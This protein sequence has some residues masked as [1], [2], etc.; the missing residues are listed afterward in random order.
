[1]IAK[2]LFRALIICKRKQSL[3]FVNI[4]WSSIKK[5]ELMILWKF[6]KN[7]SLENL[8]LSFFKISYF[9]N[10]GLSWQWQWENHPENIRSWC[11]HSLLLRKIQRWKLLQIIWAN[12]WK[13]CWY[14]KNV[15][16]NWINLNRQHCEKHPIFQKK[17]CLKPVVAESPMD[18]CLIDLVVMEKNPSKDKSNKIC[19]Y[20]RNILNVFSRFVFLMPLRTKETTEIASHLHTSF[21]HA[22]LPNVIQCDGGNEFKVNLCFL[23]VFVWRYDNY[24]FLWEVLPMFI[25]KICA[26]IC[27]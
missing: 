11:N 21:L 10:L 27:F 2:L 23:T 1:M 4:D 19:Q 24:Y 9:L 18:I 25:S 6:L 7:L 26:L 16:Q 20:I 3:Q 13:L 12:T 22:G 14:K 8:S 5:L 17:D 15:I